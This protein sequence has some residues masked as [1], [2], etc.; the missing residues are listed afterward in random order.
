MGGLIFLFLFLLWLTVCIYVA[1]QAPYW[2]AMRKLRWLVS[3]LVFALLLPL[4]LIDEIVGG[5]QFKKLCDVHNVIKIDKEKIRGSTIYYEPEP[6]VDLKNAWVSIRLQ[7]WSHS[8]ANGVMAMQYASLHANGGWLV[9]K[10]SM[11]ESS[12][13]L[14]FGAS[15]YPTE[16]PVTL[17]K[18]LN[19]TTLD[20][21]K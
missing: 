9:R 12:A 21:P 20:R 3:V 13:P 16:N 4:P 7:Q 14:L 11:S 10:L 19:V 18:S 5:W 6:N 2:F 17:K 8:Y 15:C 1:W